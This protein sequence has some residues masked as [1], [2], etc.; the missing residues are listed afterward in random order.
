MK[1]HEMHD[2]LKA[3]THYRSK[4]NFEKAL[5]AFAQARLALLC[6]MGECLTSLGQLEEGRVLFEE[7]LEANSADIRANAGIGVISL[8]AEEYGTAETAFGNVLH[9][10]PDNVKA[11]CGMGMAKRASGQ[12]EEAYSVL[13][14][15]QDKNPVHKSTLQALADVG[16]R[17]GKAAE[18]LPLLR[19]YL[20]RYPED[21]EIAI[22]ITALEELS[23]AILTTPL[24]SPSEELKNVLDSFR[25][26]PDDLSVVNELLR[27]LHQLGRSQEAQAVRA[28]FLVRNPEMTSALL[29]S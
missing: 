28:V 29:Q 26:N 20:K 18:V 14:E 17:L 24:A 10:D 3:G 7:V 22:D 9:L 4:G 13:L 25:A 16:G 11:L 6:E 19:K 8:L 5:E 1:T 27:L 15:A 23:T 12:L 2:W 21:R